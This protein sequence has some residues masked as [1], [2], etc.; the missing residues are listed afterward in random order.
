VSAPL[1]FGLVG[2]GR[3]GANAD[4]RAATWPEELRAQWL[5]YAHASAIVATPGASLVA[6][7][8][9]SEDA[10]ESTRARFGAE[11]AYTDV[12]EMLTSERLD[13]LAIATRTAERPGIVNAAVEHGVRGVYCEKPLAT[14][15]EE[16]DAMARLVRDRGVAFAYGTRRR[17]MTGYG[18]ARELLRSGAIGELRT[19]VVHFGQGGL[20]WNHPH[21]VDL[22]T[23]F[24]EDAPV[25]FVQAE[26]DLPD[27]AV[28][29]E[30]RVIDCDPVLR[31]GHL[32]FASGRRAVILPGDGQDVVLLG[33]KGNLTVAADGVRIDRR[34]YAKS[35][36]D[37]G[38]LLDEERSPAPAGPSGAAASL[39]ALVLAMNGGPALATEPAFAG[40]EVLFGF[41]ESH[42]AGGARLPLPLARRGLRVTGRTGDKLC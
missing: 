21:S 1:R 40:H 2:C 18:R 17:W 6:T 8:D 29:A 27:G 25:T 23:F 19:I 37:I 20:L 24:A 16:G 38:W 36:T 31:M 11:R 7:C 32:G 12:R 39:A 14:T 33:D 15:L 3:I 13:G 35:G 41:V 9:V 5:P 30:G 4:D 28:G 34:G 42:L 22:A 10:A 26:L